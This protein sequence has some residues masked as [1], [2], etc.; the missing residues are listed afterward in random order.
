MR[1]VSRWSNWC[2]P[3]R[4]A[5][6]PMTAEVRAGSGRPDGRAAASCGESR[7]RAPSQSPGRAP[8]SSCHPASSARR[9]W[10]THPR[11]RCA[12]SL[13]RRA[14]EGR[15]L[16]RSR[17][18]RLVG[19]PSGAVSPR[20]SVHTGLSLGLDVEEFQMAGSGRDHDP[21][22]GSGSK[23]SAMDLEPL[24]VPRGERIADPHPAMDRTAD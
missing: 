20:N 21:G 13:R 8:P 16:G 15:R 7:R 4:N 11:R 9:R 19:A 24:A 1:W 12:R 23:A 17:A 22:I 2:A 14:G 10:H 6:R 18:E 3:I 5:A